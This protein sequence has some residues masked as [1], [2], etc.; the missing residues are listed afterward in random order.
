MLAAAGV[1]TAQS[2]V[3]KVDT[4][5][6]T[7]F[8]GDGVEIKYHMQKGAGMVY[9]WKA[10]G[11]LR[12]EFHGEPDQKR[13]QDY[14]ES[15][16]L[17]DKVGQD[18]SFG[19]FIAPTTGINGWFW[20]NK[21]NQ[22]VQMHLKTA[23]FFRRRENVRRRGAGR[24]AGGRRK[25]GSF[26]APQRPVSGTANGWCD[27]RLCSVILEIRHDE[28]GGRYTCSS[29]GRQLRRKNKVSR[30]WRRLLRATGTRP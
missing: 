23:G 12:L 19:S 1:Y 21:T 9:A 2:K 7:L 29:D 27:G 24:S 13:N 26:C 18:H 15:F 10:N 3:Y 20:E 5:D 22:Q 17:D 4:E 14:Y 16:E 6:L 28:A 8:P 30:K 25:V 11:K